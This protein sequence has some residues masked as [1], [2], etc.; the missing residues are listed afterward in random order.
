M[1]VL[2]TLALLAPPT[3]GDG[4]RSV[5][6]FP[7]AVEEVYAATPPPPR[8]LPKLVIAGGAAL[9]VAGLLGA[10]LSPGCVTTD[11][12]GRC[13]DARGSHPAFPV[14]VVGGLVTATVGSYWHRR[15]D[16]AE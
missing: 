15:G 16:R 6:A 5:G 7:P 13:V 11:A 1:T 2:L 10:L 14:L 8:L 9:V 12:Q 4:L 3:L